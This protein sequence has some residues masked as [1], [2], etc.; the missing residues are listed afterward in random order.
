[1]TSR[2]SQVARWSRSDVDRLIDYYNK[3]RTPTQIAL[4]FSRERGR[5]ITP[6][7]VSSKL[8]RMAQLGDPRIKREG[9]YKRRDPDWKDQVAILLSKNWTVAR[10]AREMK[11]SSVE[12]ERIAAEHRARVRIFGRKHDDINDELSD[13]AGL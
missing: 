4:I 2:P 11:I 12:I 7:S 3:G 10:I 6:S 1:M 8:A 5:H 9:V 13:I